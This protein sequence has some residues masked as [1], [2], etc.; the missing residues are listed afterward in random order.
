MR[1]PSWIDK[2]TIPTNRGDYIL[3]RWVWCLAM[4][5]NRMGGGFWGEPMPPASATA[6]RLCVGWGR[7]LGRPMATA[8]AAQPPIRDF[9][10]LARFPNKVLSRANARNPQF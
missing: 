5:W 9:P 3:A 10:Y 8:K 1:M 7:L 4:G 2:A 6:G